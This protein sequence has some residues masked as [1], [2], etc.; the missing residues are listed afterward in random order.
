M[1]AFEVP[2]NLKI[3]WRFLN[4]LMNENLIDDNDLGSLTMCGLWS[5]T[6]KITMVCYVVN[7]SLVWIKRGWIPLVGCECNN[8]LYTMVR[9]ESWAESETGGDYIYGGRCITVV[10]KCQGLEGLIGTQCRGEWGG[11]LVRVRE[12]EDRMATGD[13]RGYAWA[14]ENGIFILRHRPT[15]I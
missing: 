12:L 6:R 4:I 2:L 14:H 5:F 10:D 11:G 3:L 15:A 1:I 7:W 8:C 13:G 9:F